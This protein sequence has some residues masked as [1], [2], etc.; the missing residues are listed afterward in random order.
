MTETTTLLVLAYLS[1]NFVMAARGWRL[2]YRFR[3]A[4]NAQ[5][6]SLS[7]CLAALLVLTLIYLPL[8]VWCRR[9]R[10]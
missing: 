4:I 3:K 6:P 7:V 8:S 2:D 5:Q 10:R 1:S 9:R